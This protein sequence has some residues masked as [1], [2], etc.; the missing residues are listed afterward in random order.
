[1]HPFL[2]IDTETTGVGSEDRLCQ[3]AFKAGDVVVNQLFKPPVSIGPLAS[4]ITHITDKHVSDKEPFI[5]SEAYLTLKVLSDN[6]IFIAHNAQFDLGMLA[7]E[8]I[9]FNKH[10]CTMKLARHLDDG[11]Y[12]NHQLQYLRYYHQLDVDT[13]GLMAHD[14]MADIIVLEAVFKHLAKTLQTRE[15]LTKEQTIDLMVDISIKPM[16]LKRINTKK[17][18]N[19]LIAD[20]AKEDP[21]YLVWLLGEKKKNPQGE[22][23]WIYT[24]THY[25]SK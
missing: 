4:S 15:K 22:D 13:A 9:T 3:I 25:L 21:Q 1:M 2:Y 23:D 7:K 20:V 18:P 14:A 5:G 8:A 11:Q 16:L 10:I 24:L 19:K 6:H 12:E 17:H